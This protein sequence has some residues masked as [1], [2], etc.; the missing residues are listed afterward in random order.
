MKTPLLL[1]YLVTFCP[2]LLIGQVSST[3]FLGKENVFS[4]YPQF[5]DVL[6]KVPEIIM[7]EF[8]PNNLLKE[9]ESNRKLNTPFRFGKAFDDNYSLDD[10][11]WINNEKEAVW[12]LKVT[13][14]G[15]YSIN[16]IFKDLSLS[17]GSE[18]YIFSADGSMVYGP[19]TS[20]QNLSGNEL[21]LTDI[22]KGESVILLIQCP[23]EEQEKNKLS[24]SRIV[25]GYKN[26]Y[27]SNTLSK[28]SG[29]CQQ[30]VACYPDWK[31]E[32]DGIAFIL[33]N[34]TNVCSGSLINNTAQDFRALILT[35]FHCVDTD[36]NG[37]LNAT[38]LNNVGN[39][40]FKFH[41]RNSSCNGQ[42]ATSITYN[43]DNLLTY[44]T[45]SDVALLELKNNSPLI[46]SCLTFLGWD[47]RQNTPS[48]T[49][50]IHHPSGDLMKISF[51]NGQPAKTAKGLETPGNYWRVM[52]D[53][54][55]T[56]PYSSGSPLFDQ[57]KR[58]V[59][60][61][62]GGN[63][64][65]GGTDL[66]DWY[67]AFDVSYSNVLSP[68]LGSANYI[69]SIRYQISGPGVV[70][71][72]NANFTL[73][74]PPAGSTITWTAS[75]VTPSSGSGA[76]ASVHSAC[77]VSVESNII[78]TISNSCICT[79]QTTVSKTYLS[80]GPSPNDVT[81]DVYK[82]NG[83]HARKAGIFLLCPNSTYYLYVN[84]N[85][86]TCSTS[87]YNW[88]L[89]PSLT[90][91]YS[92][93]NMISVNTNANPGGNVIVYATTCCSDCGSNVRILSDYV[94]K[95]TSCGYSYMIF[96]P[97]PANTE[98]VL[99]LKTDNSDD[100]VNSTEEWTFE[101]YNSQSTLMS[102]VNNLM[103]NKFNITTS[104]L[105]E[106]TYYVRVLFKDRTLTGKFTVA[107]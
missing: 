59:G 41:Y 40:A 53:I 19:V 103:D 77:Q 22:I 13:S 100:L 18:L 70:C 44:S 104:S 50:G 8:D 81:L 99:E 80:A 9:D 93:G 67:G 3:I 37:S 92:S 45:V 62:A 6:T 71:S 102:K 107:R 36:Q 90:R 15:A 60:Q 83:Q 82:S 89:P 25:H 74:N 2:I 31:T 27:S 75:N 57:N 66:R 55:T 91:N 58:I 29:N 106:G 12:A 64:F 4:I 32:S 52:W 65:C 84:N 98:T 46:G 78:F 20:R 23:F 101:L 28:S 10:G 105:K 11:K 76:T 54:G 97:N 39:W 88:T 63:S 73:L 35:A 38:E 47:R 49:V 16:F 96:A 42:L 61:L 94:G 68:Y 69:N 48:S 1:I 5:S 43:Q 17:S 72:A 79:G 95:E 26:I 24:I 85:S 56:E 34:G 7:P 87:Q 14:I 51:D 30:D 86:S 21:F 33:L